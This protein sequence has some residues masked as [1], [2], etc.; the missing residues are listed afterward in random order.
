ML[1]RIQTKY[2]IMHDATATKHQHHPFN[3]L[4]TI[5][6]YGAAFAVLAAFA[7]LGVEESRMF[8]IG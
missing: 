7:F 3:W 4:A 8:L 2:R 5:A 1:H 6:V